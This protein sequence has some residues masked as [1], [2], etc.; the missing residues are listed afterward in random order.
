[1][2][3]YLPNCWSDYFLVF[4]NKQEIAS[5]FRKLLEMLS[6]SARHRFF[7]LTNFVTSVALTLLAKLSVWQPQFI[8][9]LV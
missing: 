9:G 6:Y 3:T 1:M 4:L 8:E 7:F 2:T 5:S